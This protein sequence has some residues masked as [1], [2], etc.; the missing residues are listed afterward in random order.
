MAVTYKD[1]K[2]TT[3]Q[4]GL[5]GFKEHP[6]RSSADPR[7]LYLSRD[8]QYVL[9]RLEDL[10]NWREGLAAVEGGIGTGKTSLARRLYEL[11]LQDDE[12]AVPYYINTAAFTTP[13]DAAHGIARA[14]GVPGRRSYTDQLDSLEKFLLELRGQDRTAVLILDDAQFMAPVAL[15]AIQNML[16]F[17]LNEKLIQ[18]ILFGQQEIRNNFAQKP[19]VNER[20]IHWQTLPPLP[21]DEMIA[22]ISWRMTV[23]GR[24]EPM[25]T[26]EALNLLYDFSG[27]V[28]RP[29]VVVCG[30]V[31]RILAS[32]RK[33]EAGRNEVV[34]AIQHFKQ[35][36]ESETDE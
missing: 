5:L 1:N 28:P 14:F 8:H 25:F 27:G 11:T 34:E 19:A 32:E 24:S 20:V 22:M 18:I 26:D 15:D 16:N 3:R 29:L 6:F 21:Y 31:L 10:I 36:P 17:D 23:A 33:T 12:N 13:Y 30:T 35:R 2:L 4:L 9:S 7:F